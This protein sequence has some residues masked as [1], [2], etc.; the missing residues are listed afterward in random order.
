MYNIDKREE[1]V[2]V[3]KEGRLIAWYKLRDQG[4]EID[5]QNLNSFTDV[6]VDLNR[7][8]LTNDVLSGFQTTSAPVK[9]GKDVKPPPAKNTKAP[10]TEAEPEYIEEKVEE[11]VL[12][13]TKP[14]NYNLGQ[15]NA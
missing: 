3:I 5:Q 15:P 1:A 9:G 12:D 6:L 11:I 4:I 13:F 14:V 2:D 10:V 8:E 7:K